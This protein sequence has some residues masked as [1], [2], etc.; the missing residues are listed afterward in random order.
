MKHIV[1]FVLFLSFSAPAIADKHGMYQS[2]QDMA[3]D[4]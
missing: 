3:D 1:L 4:G 2:V